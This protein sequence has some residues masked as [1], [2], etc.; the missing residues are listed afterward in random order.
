MNE[1]VQASKGNTYRAFE[2]APKLLHGI[3]NV[4]SPTVNDEIHAPM[5]GVRDSGRGRTGP[6]SLADFTD[7]I[8]INTTSGERQFPV[9]RLGG[10]A[11][12]WGGPW[13]GRKEDAVI[14]TVDIHHHMLRMLRDV[15]GLDHVLFGSDYPY[16][17][18]DLAVSSRQHIHASPELTDGERKAILRPQGGCCDLHRGITATS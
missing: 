7:V 10:R 16:L 18:R 9:L 4:N 11:A 1:Q 3:V 13:P 6:D 17:R 12:G 8:W 15:V 5:G 2:L 14:F